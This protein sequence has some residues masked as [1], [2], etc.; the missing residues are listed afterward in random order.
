MNDMFDTRGDSDNG[1]NRSGVNTPPIGP[2][3]S[4]LVLIIDSAPNCVPSSR[5][6]LHLKTNTPDP[7]TE[8]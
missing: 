5:S 4:L 3:S 7:V 2:G 6:I 8:H 1:D